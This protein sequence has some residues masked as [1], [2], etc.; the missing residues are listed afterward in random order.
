MS[1]P[2]PPKNV[3]VLI[4]DR[5]HAGF[6]GAYGNTWI[7]TPNLD[8]LAGDSFLFDRAMIDSPR[9]ESL[10][11]SDWEGRHALGQRLA[12]GKAKPQAGCRAAWRTLDMTWHCGQ[13]N[14]RLPICRTRPYSAG[15]KCSSHP[16]AAE[17]PPR[18]K[19][20]I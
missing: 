2:Q 16:P 10:Y 3:V 6:V 11:R 17:L 12:R 9:L 1:T 19:R 7:Q 15:W 13:T 14:R 4:V 20:P 5:L 8:R 18:W